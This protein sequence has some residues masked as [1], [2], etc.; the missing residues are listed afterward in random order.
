MYPSKF[1]SNDIECSYASEGATGS[2]P[3]EDQEEQSPEID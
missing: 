1:R 2:E 3:D